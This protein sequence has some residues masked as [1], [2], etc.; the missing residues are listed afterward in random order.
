MVCTTFFLVWYQS[1]RVNGSQ[2]AQWSL[3]AEDRKA[4]LDV[5]YADKPENDVRRMK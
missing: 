1:P 5:A 3:I 4:G 2:W